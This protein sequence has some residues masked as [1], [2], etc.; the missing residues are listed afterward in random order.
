MDGNGRWAKKR[1]LPRT[2]GHK[3][4]IERIEEVI[5]DAK[6]LGVKILTLFAFS[7]ENWSRPKDEVEFLFSYLEDFLIKRREE[8]NKENIRVNFIG[9]RDRIRESLLKKMKEVEELTKSNQ[10][11]ILNI[12]IDYGGRWDIINAVSNLIK[13]MNKGILETP[14][15]DEKLFQE[16]LCLKDLP[17]PDLLI[18]TSGEQRISNFLLW[19]IAYTEFYFSPV[20]WP[21]F[22]KREFEKA[23]EEYS[24]RER[25]FGRIEGKDG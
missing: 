21:D 3:R 10:D 15:I 7:T 18:R 4:G 22:D 12:A 25:R 19:Q 11:L 20:F 24:K 16:Y 9:R 14:Q 23:I 8:L 13:D 17:Y 6:E 5:K 1:G 2:L